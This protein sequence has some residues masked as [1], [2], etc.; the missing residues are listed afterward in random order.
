MHQ[1]K[2]P[3]WTFFSI[4][5]SMCS[6]VFISWEILDHVTSQGSALK[7]LTCKQLS[8]KKLGDTYHLLMDPM[9][10]RVEKEIAPFC[11]LDAEIFPQQGEI[12]RELKAIKSSCESDLLTVRDLQGTVEVERLKA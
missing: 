4:L 10:E 5:N 7:I 1:P 2:L 9:G 3:S 8:P 11:I 12:A 6:N